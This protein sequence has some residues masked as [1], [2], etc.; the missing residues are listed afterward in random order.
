MSYGL[1]AQFFAI[2]PSYRDPEISMTAID[3]WGVRPAEVRVNRRGIT[4]FYKFEVFHNGLKEVRSVGDSSLDLAARKA[5]AQLEKMKEKWFRLQS[6][7]ATRLHKESGKENAESRTES[8]LADLASVKT[9][10]VDGL[11]RPARVNWSKLEQR[12]PF[13]F[14]E[15]ALFPLV[16]FSNS[17]EP[18]APKAF[19]MPTAPEA[20][21]QRYNPELS[22]IEKLWS[23]SREKKRNQSKALLDQDIAQWQLAAA[24]VK[25]KQETARRMLVEAQTAFALA[26]STFEAAQAE[27]NANISKFKAAYLVGEKDAVSEFCDMLLSTSTYPD[28]IELK[29]EVGFNPDNGMAVIECELPDKGVIPTLLKVTYVAVSNEIKEKHISDAERDRLYDSLLYQIALRTSFE[30]FN[31]DTP[32]HLKI[33]VFNGWVNALNPATGRR[34]HGC[35]LSLQAGKNE[36]QQI[37]LTNVDPRAC[38]RQLKGVSASRLSGLT[39]VRPILQLQTNDPRFV[40]AHAVADQLESGYNLAT[41]EWEEFEHLVRELF[42]SEFG[43]NGAEVHVTR[44]SLDGGVDAVVLDP[45]PIRGGK[46]VIQAKRY[47]N[48]VGLSAVRDLYGTVINEGANRG[49]LVSTADYGSDSYEFVKG[50][51]ISLLNGSNLLSLLEKHGHKARIDLRE[52]KIVN[53]LNRETNPGRQADK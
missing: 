51:P 31:A 38:F 26:K 45:D 6:Q 46:I 27:H 52:A 30:L 9:A 13:R 48:T 24:A 36:F 12:D 4:T 16:D 39:P 8:A 34:D 53:A 44:A 10:L 35:I 20:S 17:G 22:L 2:R 1:N 18:L 28:F 21:A 43:K 29:F 41:M 23:P 49:I 7:E 47:T 19:A 40:T 32:N 15:T 42:E 3:E 50:K 25:E 14:T 37:D 5:E 11:A 33:I